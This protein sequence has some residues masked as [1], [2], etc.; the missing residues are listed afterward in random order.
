MDKIKE[1]LDQGRVVI[2]KAGEPATPEQLAEAVLEYC[3]AAGYTLGEVQDLDNGIGR[4]IRAMFDR[5]RCMKFSVD[6]ADE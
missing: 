2:T 5:C 4:G 3:E 6:Q 1:L